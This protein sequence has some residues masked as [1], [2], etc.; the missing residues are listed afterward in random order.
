M[1]N[2]IKNVLV[3]LVVTKSVC[4]WIVKTALNTALEK[5]KDEKK[6]SEVCYTLKDGAALLNIVALACEDGKIDGDEDVDIMTSG[7]A[8]GE[9]LFDL[10]KG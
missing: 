4:A 1:W 3:K 5:S 7:W 9:R 6:R 10:I 2:A 8:L